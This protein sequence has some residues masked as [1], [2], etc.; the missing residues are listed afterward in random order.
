MSFFSDSSN[1]NKQLYILLTIVLVVAILFFIFTKFFYK[2]PS[3]VIQRATKP[4]TIHIDFGL[5]EGSTMRNLRIYRLI[6][7]PLLSATSAT[8]VSGISIGRPNPFSP[9]H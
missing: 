4:V 1:K 5:L 9:Y 6:T 7:L 3:K 2:S 8:S